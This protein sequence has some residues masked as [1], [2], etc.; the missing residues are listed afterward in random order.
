MLSCYYNNSKINLY[1][2]YIGIEFL[3]FCFIILF[4]FYQKN[5]VYIFPY[6]F[7]V[8]WTETKNLSI[9]NVFVFIILYLVQLMSWMSNTTN[10]ALIYV[11][12]HKHTDWLR[13]VSTTYLQITR[14]VNILLPHCFVCTGSG[15]FHFIT[16]FRTS[17]CSDLISYL[18]HC[19]Q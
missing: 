11:P 3:H 19:N 10:H 13:Y 1:N 4:E 12:I 15:M 14:T 17:V 9:T 16:I 5:C 7:D 2:K 8:T 6:P 18:V